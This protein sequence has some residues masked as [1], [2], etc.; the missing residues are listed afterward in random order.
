ML[1]KKPKHCRMWNGVDL[2]L[3]A[4]SFDKA[5]LH[6]VLQF[7]KLFR[8]DGFALKCL[9][10][11]LYDKWKTVGEATVTSQ[12]LQ[13]HGKADRIYLD[14]PKEL[15]TVVGICPK[16][17]DI[18]LGEPLIGCEYKKTGR[19]FVRVCVGCT[20]YSELFEKDLVITEVEGE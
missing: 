12:R 8:W 19:L 20:Y 7:L 16:C 4:E 11:L 13:K 5:H 17:G 18:L 1:V 14:E 10:W 6:T 15:S 2:E 9:Q 3:Y